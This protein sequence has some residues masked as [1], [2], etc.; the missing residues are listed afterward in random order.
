MEEVEV[1][2]ELGRVRHVASPVDYMLASDRLSRSHARS[3]HL[4]LKEAARAQGKEGSGAFRMHR[5]EVDFVPLASKAESDDLSG[6]SAAPPSAAG[7]AAPSYGGGAGPGSAVEGTRPEEVGRRVGAGHDDLRPEE[8]EKLLNDPYLQRMLTGTGYVSS[9][10][11]DPTVKTPRA[12][13]FWMLFEMARSEGEETD[14]GAAVQAHRK[15]VRVEQT[16]IR[17]PRRSAGG[18]AGA[19]GARK[20]ATANVLVRLGDGGVHV[21]GKRLDEAFPLMEDRREALSPLLT[22]GVAGA[23]DVR[24]DVHGGGTSGQAGAVK[25][26]LARALAR[27]DPGLH[28]LLKRL[29]MLR[30]DPRMVERKKPGRK[31]AR[32]KFQWVKR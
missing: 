5:D 16:L 23:F 31:K 7:A 26:G 9:L 17:A 30:R 18:W 10:D 20:T 32:K 25:H 21:N 11:W 12:M 28:P 13:P 6:A 14:G 24:V 27:F 22:L 8:R 29:G 1:E 4:R 15:Q 2:D 3:E 19:R